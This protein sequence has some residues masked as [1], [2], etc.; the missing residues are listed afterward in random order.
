MKLDRAG[1]IPSCFPDEERLSPR[2]I[3][4]IIVAMALVALLW[5]L[6]R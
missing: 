1:F 3:M 2:A 6:L 5:E 4:L